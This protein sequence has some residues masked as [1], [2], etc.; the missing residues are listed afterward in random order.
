LRATLEAQRDAYTTAIAEHFPAGTRVSRPNGG[1][2]LWVEL[3]P[4]CDS[5]ALWRQAMAAGI[6]IAPGPM[7]SAS[8]AFGNCMR[9]NYGHPFDAR[10]A[11]ALAQLGR[12]AASA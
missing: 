2:F 8:G 3:P 1:Y 12:I 5:L 10:V 11:A 7:F 6:S 9:I 4:G